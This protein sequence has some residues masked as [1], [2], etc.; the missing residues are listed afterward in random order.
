MFRAPEVLLE[1]RGPSGSS[2]IILTP[3]DAD[4]IPS[5]LRTF[6]AGVRNPD[7]RRVLAAIAETSAERAQ[8]E[9]ASAHKQEA[10]ALARSLGMR[11][12]SD[13]SPAPFGWDGA[14]LS[15]QTE[16]YVL[17]HEIA[18]YQLAPAERRGLIEFGLGPGPDTRDIEGAESAAVLSGTERDREEAMASLLGILWEVRLRQ[19]ALASFLDQNWLEGVAGGRAARHFT[20]VLQSLRDE[21][22]VNAE[23][24]PTLRLR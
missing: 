10:L 15:D 19:P 6:A 22:F 8:G 5:A 14:L 17:L 21:G 4:G 1:S 9:L 16:A 2:A 24:R 18:H 7:A 13:Q 11:V 3:I 20:S 12:R 23:A